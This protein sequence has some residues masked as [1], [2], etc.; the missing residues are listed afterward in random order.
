MDCYVND[1][2]VSRWD[3]RSDES[4]GHHP[5]LPTQVFGQ[6][7]LIDSGP[8]FLVTV[9]LTFDNWFFAWYTFYALLLIIFSWIFI[10]LQVCP[11]HHHELQY[12]RV[13]QRYFGNGL[14]L[15][16]HLTELDFCSWP[17][18]LRRCSIHIGMP[19]LSPSLPLL[20]LSLPS[21]SSVEPIA[22]FQIPCSL[23]CWADLS[24]P[25]S[26]PATQSTV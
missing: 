2:Q 13:I 3:R 23:L 9:W 18:S 26:S 21:L 12:R 17:W 24:L 22:A 19:Y 8:T 6:W 25:D 1:R 15:I 11:S 4:L 5:F 10:A 14:N 16:D 7:V 20:S